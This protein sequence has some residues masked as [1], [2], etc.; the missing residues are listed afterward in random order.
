MNEAG[1]EPATGGA[2]PKLLVFLH[3]PLKQRAFQGQLQAAL[4]GV[5][6]SAV[7]RPAD[8]ERGLEDHPDAVLTLPMVLA[9]HHLTA[10]LQGLHR[11]AAEEAYVLAGVDA[12]PDPARVATVGVI[13]V[14][15]REGMSAF[16]TSLLGAHPK[17][18]RVTKVEDLLPLLQLQR[19]EAILLPA[20]L[21]EEVAAPSRLS[22]VPRVL[23]AKVGLPAV[24]SLGSGGGRVVQGVRRLPPA[25]TRE[26]GVTEWR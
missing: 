22:L 24:A 12:A 3:T 26:L 8:F 15:G 14:L 10:T 19:V 9:A 4:P 20:R 2:E 16:V 1:S 6:V 21:L 13:D 5:A 7:G 11:G 17:V 18:E 25:V 23:A